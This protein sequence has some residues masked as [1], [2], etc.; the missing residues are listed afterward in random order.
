MNSLQSFNSVASDLWETTPWPPFLR[1]NFSGA[2]LLRGNS[3]SHFSTPKSTDI[4]GHIFIRQQ[5][6]P[7]DSSPVTRHSLLFKLDCISEIRDTPYEADY[8]H[9]YVWIAEPFNTNVLQH[10]HQKI[11]ITS[12]TYTIANDYYIHHLQRNRK[13]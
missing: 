6:A 5:I 9:Y 8:S 12:I 10:F 13:T 3:D 11:M 4:M 1:G 2:P 7:I